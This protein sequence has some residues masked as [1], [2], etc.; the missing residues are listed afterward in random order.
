[1]LEGDT[2]VEKPYKG[3]IANWEK[4]YFSKAA[5]P[6]HKDTLGYVIMGV[7]IGHPQYSEWIVTSP[8]VK[9]EEDQ[10]ETLNSRYTLLNP[11]N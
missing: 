5:F 7:P 2:I 10:I 6:Q 8:V 4:R 11:K 3:Q 1:M 9:H